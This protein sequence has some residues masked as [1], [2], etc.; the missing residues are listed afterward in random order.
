MRVNSSLPA[1]F[2]ALQHHVGILLVCMSQD[3][4]QEVCDAAT[5]PDVI[6]ETGMMTPEHVEDG[7]MPKTDTEA[8]P[9]LAVEDLPSPL[10]AAVLTA[11]GH[12]CSLHR[13]RLPGHCMPASG[14]DR[15]WHRC[16]LTV[17]HAC[18]GRPSQRC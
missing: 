5:S 10:P 15:Q 18:L 1:V 7:Q 14:V 12:A 11:I 2:T 4:V 3:A 6:V 9:V 17:R 13:G 8:E 16:M